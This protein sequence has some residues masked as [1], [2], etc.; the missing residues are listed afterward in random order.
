MQRECPARQ[1]ATFLPATPAVRRATPCR[2]IDTSG[3]RPVYNSRAYVVFPD[4]PGSCT[5][6]FFRHGVVLGQSEPVCSSEPAVVSIP[7]SMTASAHA[8]GG[9]ADVEEKEERAWEVTRKYCKHL[10]AVHLA[11]AIS[12]SMSVVRRD[13][14]TNV[15]DD[16]VWGTETAGAGSSLVR[17]GGADQGEVTVQKQP[18]VEQ[19]ERDSYWRMIATGR[20]A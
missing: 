20:S 15:D 1:Y 11:L 5:C 2:D 9:G 12:A 16:A 17:S 18:Y 14:S 6:S 19:V 8:A 3:A 10:L 4:G 7:K 13:D